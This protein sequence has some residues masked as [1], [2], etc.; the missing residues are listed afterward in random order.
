M[1]EQTEVRLLC[2]TQ[3]RILQQLTMEVQ[4]NRC[5]QE[6][7]YRHVVANKVPVPF[8]GVEL[9]RESTSVTQGLWG[10]RLM[11]HSGEPGDQG[12]LAANF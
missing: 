6:G 9:D 7:T 3:A 11:N 10:A 2:T 4:C 1:L 8:I 5:K 12:S